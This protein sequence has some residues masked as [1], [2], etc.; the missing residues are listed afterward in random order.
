ME[1]K[2]VDS[3]QWT[4]PDVF[5]Y[6]CTYERFEAKALRG[7]YATFRIV[8]RDIG[9]YIKMRLSGAA[10]TLYEEIAI[11]V[12]SNPN[13]EE[14]F[15]P[16]FPERI[17]PFSVYDCMKPYTQGDELTPKNQVTS[18][19]VAIEVSHDEEDVIDGVLLIDYEN[20][21]VSIPIS[22][23]PMGKPVNESLKIA[24]GYSV[25]D[26]IRMHDLDP[27]TPEFQEIHTKYLKM[28]RHQH[29]NVMFLPNPWI[30]KDE[31]GKWQFR[32]ERFNQL[33]K[34]AIELGFTSFMI[35]GVG[36]RKA[37]DRPEIIVQGMDC[38]S[39]EAFIFISQYLTALRNNL[40]E[41]GWLK[42]GMFCIGVADE[43]NENDAITYR[44]LSGMVRKYLPEIKI[45]DAVSYVEVYGAIDVWVPRVDEYYKN[46]EKFDQ[47]KEAGDELWHYV[48]L[49]PRD[50]GFVNRFMD[51]PLLSTRYIYWT[52]Y[53]YSL[54]GYLHW[55]INM[56]QGD[57]DPY[58][59]S[60][61][62]H[63]NAG[64]KSIL[65]AGDDKL[66]YPGNN[67][68]YMSARLE[69]HRESAEEYE[70][71]KIISEEDKELADEICKMCCRSYIDVDYEPE[72]F[73]AA[74]NR[75]ITEYNRI[76]MNH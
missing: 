38:L 29:Q 41:N 49:Y 61:P 17:A 39:Y 9:S 5:D 16:H 68:P 19:Y 59:A 54:T 25:H 45:Y 27:R 48:C 14:G 37:W 24:M 46:K 34:N 32:F 55:S 63:I 44:A 13:F 72:K 7:S 6:P 11:P 30:W 10:G 73:V 35:N 50:G 52:N 21:A 64:S 12:E 57:L 22:V 3:C 31:D 70:M 1:Y 18:V 47:F 71:L 40:K 51:I 42:S 62:E 33:I 26:I 53:L 56:Y 76:T 2:I 74:R 75:L 58:K 36:F 69:A 20:G 28:M 15:K 67:E 43:P 23:T 65:P 66:V 4:Y 8:F 60:C